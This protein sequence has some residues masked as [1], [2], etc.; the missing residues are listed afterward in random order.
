MPLRLSRPTWVSRAK[1]L[2]SDPDL[3]FPE[4]GNANNSNA[5]LAKAVCNGMDG[6]PACPVRWQCLDLALENKEKLGIWG[7]KSERERKLIQRRRNDN[8]PVRVIKPGKALREYLN[9]AKVD[10][11]VLGELQRHVLTRPPSDRA[12]GIHP[13]EMSS[14][15]WCPRSTYYRLTEAPTNPGDATTFQREVVFSEGHDI[16]RKWQDWLWKIG[17]LGGEWG[18]LLCNHVWEAKAPK[19]CPECEAPP[20]LIRYREVPL[21]NYD[22]GIVGHADGAIDDDALVEIKSVGL[23]TVR[24]EAPQL[25]AAHTHTVTIN[26]AEKT[27]VDYDGLWRD[28]TRP[29]PSHLRQGLL[30]LFLAERQVM[31]YLYECK[32]NQQVKEFVVR[33]T[34]ELIEDLLDACLDVRYAVK[35]E[36][37]P[38]RPG[39]AT[40]A[41]ADACKGCVFRS[42]C[43]SLSDAKSLN[44][45]GGEI[46]PGQG[47]AGKAAPVPARETAVRDPQSPDHPGRPGGQGPDEPLREAGSLAQLPRWPAGGDRSRRTLRRGPARQ[48]AGPG[49]A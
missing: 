8:R 42:H 20:E 31:V 33:Y 5:N 27:V 49:P 4:R 21:H 44:G 26:G 35:V 18:C 1:C 37:P 40:D 13:S 15:K 46:R 6:Q 29:L 7:G 45:T 10:T 17:R 25:L 23:G 2:G 16:H 11:Y 34:P 32:W 48:G 28:I 41:D 30:Y 14:P 24:M 39:W 43:W 3:F 38:E 22:Y 19:A 12:E 47:R 9:T 36:R